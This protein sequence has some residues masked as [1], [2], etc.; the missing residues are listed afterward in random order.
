MIPKEGGDLQQDSVAAPTATHQTLQVKTQRRHTQ[1]ETRNNKGDIKHRTL[2]TTHKPTRPMG[3][4]SRLGTAISHIIEYGEI[5]FKMNTITEE[6]FDS[7]FVATRLFSA[8]RDQDLRSVKMCIKAR[9]NVNVRC[10]KT[11]MTYVHLTVKTALPISEVK[12]V[13]II[14][15]L[16]NADIDLNAKDKNGTTA[17]YLSIERQLLEVMA[18]LLRCGA[19]FQPNAEEE[20]FSCLRGPFVYEIL[21]RYKS[22]SPGYWDALRDGKA[23]RVNVLV[24]SWCRINISRHGITLI[25][26]AKQKNASEKVVRQLIDN[27][28]TI[29]FA[30]ATIAGD[31]EKMRHLLLHYPV[32]LSTTDL[33]HRE[34][35]FEPYSPLTLQGAAIKYGH[36]DALSI[37]KEAEVNRQSQTEKDTVK[38]SVICSIS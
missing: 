25:E 32:D 8:I 9:D 6:E 24:K 27:E 30:H 13:P 7:E 22:F 4:R 12:Y 31:C 10:R 14:H 18:A 23:F 17:L 11:G 19:H 38:S 3:N 34:N 5:K 21:N 2:K 28:A 20:V 1:Q 16:S 37:L 36:K 35:F 33:S 26:Y 15:Q 29:E